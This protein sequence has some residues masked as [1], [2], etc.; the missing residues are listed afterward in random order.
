MK[1]AAEWKLTLDI[2]AAALYLI[3]GKH[4]LLSAV[5]FE[6]HSDG[7]DNNSLRPSKWR[8]SDGCEWPCTLHDGRDLPALHVS[9]VREARHCLGIESTRLYQCCY[10]P[11]PLGLL[12]VGT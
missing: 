9:N 2:V 12:S 6:T 4:L 11:Y 3:D 8:L 10:D 7:T 5:H 1:N